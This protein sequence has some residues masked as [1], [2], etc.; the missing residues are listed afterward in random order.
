MEKLDVIQPIKTILDGLN[1]AIWSQEMS[2]FLKGRRLWRI[3][4][5]SVLAPVQ[6]KDEADNAY[7]ERLE[8]WESKNHQILTWIRNTSIPSIKL[9]FARFDTA[10]EVWDLLNT[11]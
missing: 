3:V 2:S 1:F 5:G 8:D 10:K 9:Q 11:R 7:W 6:Q 4:T